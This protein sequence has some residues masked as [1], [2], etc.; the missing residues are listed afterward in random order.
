MLN[1]PKIEDIVKIPEKIAVFPVII[2]DKVFIGANTIIAKGVHIGNN[3]VIS[4]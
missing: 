2:E 3:S 1:P 4:A